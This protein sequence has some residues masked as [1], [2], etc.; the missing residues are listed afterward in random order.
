M[1]AYMQL[2]D[3]NL[4]APWTA[5]GVTLRVPRQ[6]GLIPPPQRPTK[7]KDDDQPPAEV[8]DDRQPD[9]INLELPG[10]VGAFQAPLE[11]VVEDNSVI[12]H[13][14]FL[15]LLCNQFAAPGTKLDPA[16]APTFTSDFLDRLTAAL[17]VSID[18]RDPAAWKKE[19]FPLKRE[20]FLK[21]IDLEVLELLPEDPIDDV[22]TRFTI[23]RF[24]QEGTQVLIMTVIPD[25]VSPSERLSERIPLSLGTL[26]VNPGEM[27][28]SGSGGAPAAGGA[29]F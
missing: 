13:P 7:K 29:S 28:S 12:S 6:F 15:Y 11:T 16:K 21:L 22:P 1:F 25:T 8:I 18:H 19:S 27:V 17:H 4:A 9:Y 10:L 24:E 2:L 26:V 3:D 20:P 5:F 14:G 23:Y